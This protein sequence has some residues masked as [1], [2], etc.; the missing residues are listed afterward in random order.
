MPVE[1]G[2]GGETV[3][4]PV[5]PDMGGLAAAPVADGLTAGGTSTEDGGIVS[6]GIEP[7]VPT[8]PVDAPGSGA[9]APGGATPC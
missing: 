2:M 9:V 1:D 7:L 5:P 3:V 4:G 6:A 8:D